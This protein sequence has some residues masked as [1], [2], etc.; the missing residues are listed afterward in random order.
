MDDLISW[1]SGQPL[2]IQ[3]ILRTNKPISK[4]TIPD[5]L[6]LCL[7]E[8]KQTL[9]LSSGFPTLSFSEKTAKIELLSLEKISGISQL[10][11]SSKITFSPNLSLIY[12]RNGSGKT[13]YVNIID[14][15]RN[16]INVKLINNIYKSKK[17]KQQ[18][19]IKY[20]F[21][22]SESEFTYPVLEEFSSDN[23]PLRNIDIFRDSKESLL[24]G[25]N[26]CSYIPSSLQFLAS[27]SD[28]YDLIKQNLTE[29]QNMLVSP[30]SILPI[31]YSKTKV[32]NLFEVSKNNVSDDYIKS[33][34]WDE[35][36]ESDLIN[37]I[38]RLDTAKVVNALKETENKI[39]K[40]SKLI[41]YYESI[42]SIVSE[43]SLKELS[44]LANFA[45]EKKVLVSEATRVL[46]SESII[47]G[48][49]SETW[50]ELWH[51]AK[52]YSE[53]EVYSN[54]SYPNVSNDAVCVLCHQKLDEKSKNRMI[55]F[56]NYVSGTISEQYDQAYRKY[57]KH[58]I[59]QILI[60]LDEVFEIIKY[61]EI[62][63]VQIKAFVS[64]IKKIKSWTDKE[65]NSLADKFNHP[66]FLS[67]TDEFSAL[68][69]FKANLETLKE[70]HEKDLD[71]E[72][73]P[74]LKEQLLELQAKKWIF[75]HK[76]ELKKQQIYLTELEIYTKAISL[77]KTNKI[78]TKAK[79]LGKELLTDKFVFKFNESLKKLGAE[80]IKVELSVRSPKKG[81]STFCLKLTDCDSD[82]EI[83]S[84][85]SNGERRIVSLAAVIAE[86]SLAEHITPFI[87]DDPISSLDFEYEKSL[88]IFLKELSQI[89][90]VIVFTHRLS[91]IANLSKEISSSIYRI[92]QIENINGL[93]AGISLTD[94]ILGNSNVK[95]ELNKL[96]DNINK[97]IKNKKENLDLFIN[98]YKEWINSCCSTYRKLIELSIETILLGSTVERFGVIH[99][100]NVK[101]LYLINEDDCKL[102]DD[103]MTKYSYFEHSQPDDVPAPSICFEDLKKDCE[104]F[105][106][107]IKDFNKRVD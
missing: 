44:E 51:A 54:I 11:S 66:Q 94:P 20:K 81:R 45:I 50:K 82:A 100:N 61:L 95:T 65:R 60:N 76:E 106:T 8:A 86:S 67:M 21:N 42:I 83:Q 13:S 35:K 10:S 6:K 46:S 84:I 15:A 38:N 52:N 47:C 37:I 73:Q 87:F 1:L 104:I 101:K 99:P 31:S 77:T 41:L 63:E 88:S 2:W 56:N 80:K 79:N 30:L 19:L 98:N 69:D 7:E 18:Y 43:N 49:G 32:G 25:Q 23:N 24:L 85:L 74:K 107:W 16:P 33:I 48:V 102:L 36:E 78:T 22:D 96:I 29:K 9:N 90:Q 68:I 58:S 93:G 59:F 12:G 26:D 64:N 53:K 71:S 62:E 3:E 105:K 89:R 17:E 72:N 92:I 14:N 97:Y 57:L 28:F 34:L 4:S 75:D 40:L 70:Q 91:F 39:L 103:N 5:A 27:L 55:N